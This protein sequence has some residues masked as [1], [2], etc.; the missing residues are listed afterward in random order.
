MS[1][2]TKAVRILWNGDRRPT[3]HMASSTPVLKPGAQNGEKAPSG[4]PQPERFYYK[5]HVDWLIN[6]EWLQPYEACLAADAIG[7][8]SSTRILDRRFTLVQFA[9]L[10][11]HLSGSTAEA[12]VFRGVG[13]A[14]ICKALEGSYGSGQTHWGFDSFEGLPSPDARDR[15]K[16]PEFDWWKKG[17]LTVPEATARE[18]LRPYSPCRI[19]R[20]WIPKCLEPAANDRFRFVHIDVDLA[21]PTTDC[22]TFFYPRLVP[23]AVILFD[24]YGIA[25]CPGARTSVDDFFRDKPEN[26]VE[27][28]TGQA[29]V[30]KVD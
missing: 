5:P 27:L 6:R 28:A 2:L 23:G 16:N 14:I 11:K 25:S 26:V 19:E 24:D 8:Q 29:F 7:N 13:S 30:I 10:A 3:R 4:E 22:L 18:Y 21:T 9:K 20:G 15:A 17:S 12:G 1:R